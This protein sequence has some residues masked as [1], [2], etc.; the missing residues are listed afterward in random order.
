MRIVSLLPSATE[1][2]CALGLREQL[3]G[4]SH[5]CDYPHSV[6][7]LPVVTRTRM[8]HNATSREIDEQ[9]RRELESNQALYSLNDDV[10]AALAPD[11]IVTQSLCDVCAVAEADVSAAACTLP[12]A[13]AIFNLQPMNLGDVLAT[14]IA[15][16]DAAA[17]H[18][19]GENLRRE[20]TARI[21][22]VRARSAAIPME[23]QPR[24]VFLE[25]VDPPFNA[26]H[27]TP[28]IIHIA[29]GI[30]LLGAAGK[31]SSTI[32]WDA[33]AAA[34]PDHIVIGCCG[35]DIARAQREIDRLMQDPGHPAG[36]TLDR[37]RVS[38]VDGNA[39]FN[40]PGPRLVDSLELMA[41]V[42]HPAQHPLP[43]SVTPAVAR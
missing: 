4:V 35:F 39:Y 6:V 30:P 40:R 29:G 37:T 28:E 14:T 34:E 8:D 31:P 24:V 41:H 10:L 15:L 17:S 5:E 12:R 27:W 43:A 2:I 7:G 33:V 1:F 16:A 9:V 23:A 42:L 20:M 22:S 13:P 32:S 19:A 26:G 11:L 18:A 36:E 3:V 21:D 25:W 38:F